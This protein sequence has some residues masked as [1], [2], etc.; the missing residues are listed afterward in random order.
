MDNGG[1]LEKPLEAIRPWGRRCKKALAAVM[2]LSAMGAACSACFYALC[3]SAA[4]AVLMEGSGRSLHLLPW[5][6]LPL[7]IK[8]LCDIARSCATTRMGRDLECTVRSDIASCLIACGPFSEHARPEASAFISDAP[9]EITP[10]FKDYLASVRTAIAI[11]VVMLGA[12]ALAS[13]MVAIALLVASPLLP[14]FMILI[15]KG[16]EKLN[17]RQWAG[18]M[19]LSSLFLEAL[20]SIPTIRIFSLERRE[21]E[22]IGKS[23]ELW[24]LETMKVLRVAFLS[25]LALE[26]FATGGI[27]FCAMALGFAVYEH[28]FG[29]APALFA[30]MCVPE[31]FMPLR[32]MGASYYSRMHSLGVLLGMARMLQEGRER[33]A[34]DAAAPKLEKLP[35]LEFKDVIAK[36]PDGRIGISSF[37]ARFESGRLYVL[38]GPSGCGKSTV[39]SMASGLLAPCGGTIDAG[40]V[41]LEGDACRALLPLCTFIP[42]SP[43][44]FPSS[45][46]EN[47]LLGGSGV[48]DDALK[49]VLR[50]VGLWDAIASRGGLDLRLGDRRLGLSGG[51][52]RLLA[53]ARALLRRSSLIAL[54]EPTASLDHRCEDALCNLLFKSRGSAIV[55]AASHRPDLI[56]RADCVVEAGGSHG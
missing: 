51:Q 3:A 41:A 35:Y 53:F 25:A 55:I 22:L 7:S 27:A 30:L 42:Q 56:A 4:A 5:A 31:F 24:R 39:L 50:D 47:L 17:Q 38:K 13:P 44:I 34:S 18:I 28:G 15:G 20:R 43:Y 19:R 12:T 23:S 54:D 16:A 1:S 8:L 36:Y 32:A 49:A 45:V 2:A 14:V 46:R 21:S 26:F 37:S 40:G 10:Y 6:L 11:P 9:G 29:A 48:G 33:L 52:A